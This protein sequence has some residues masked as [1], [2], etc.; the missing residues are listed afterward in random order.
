MKDRL[1][2]LRGFALSFPAGSPVRVAYRDCRRFLANAA[3]DVA[4]AGNTTA[5]ADGPRETLQALECLQ[6]IGGH[7]AEWQELHD[8]RSRV[9]K[10]G[11]PLDI[12]I[13]EYIVLCV[14][15]P[16]ETSRPVALRWQRAE[17]YYFER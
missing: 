13:G 10:V 3:E 14:P 7:E 8:L 17:D 2:A 16:S 5:C 11:A 6:D 12:P 4:A 1:N 9:R 15:V